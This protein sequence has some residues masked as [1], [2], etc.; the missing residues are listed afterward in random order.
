MRLATGGQIDRAQALSFTFDGRRYQGVAGDTLAS[1]L[2]ANDVRL[3]GRSFKYH[4]R[5]GIF[6]AGSEEPNALVTLGSGAEQDPNQRA[7]MVELVDGLDARSQNRWPSLDYDLLALN[8]L[9]APFLGAGFYYKTFMWPAKFWERLYEPLIRRAAGLG[10]LSGQHNPDRYERAFANCDLLVIGAGPAGLMAALEAGRAGLDVILCDEDTRPGGRLNAER[11]EVGGQ[12]G[13]EWAAGVVA[14]LRALA[15]VRVM[16]RTTVTGAYDGGTYGA[17]E[18]LSPEVAARDGAPQACFWRITARRA[19]LA[20]GALERPVAFRNNDRPG[21]M[22]AGALRTYVNRWAVAPGRSVVVFGNNDDAHR[23]VA[24]LLAAGVHVAALVDSRVDAHTDL[25][26]RLYAGAQ[27]CNVQGRSGVA[28]VSIATAGGVEKVQ[29]DC[30][31]MSGGWNP[32]LHL[33]C[34][35]GGRPEWSP[36]LAA[37]IP[38]AGAVPGMTAAGACAGV[39]STHGCLTAGAV[40]ARAVIDDLGHRAPA[41]DLPQAEDAPYRIAPLWTVPGK[42]RAWLDFQNDVTVKDVT[43]AA[44]ENFTSVEHMKRYTTQG[45][46]PDQGTRGLPRNG[47]PPATRPAPGWARR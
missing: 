32:T 44:A 23:T 2:M 34:H 12:S 46:A 21:V 40:A 33:T 15:N 9:A 43:Q 10:A 31:A 39:F 14:E 30:L 4:R 45:M 28:S 13:A 29:A 19:I 22:M 42:G 41:T 26:V 16:T 20:A 38:R 7:T 1:A 25:P 11:I 6:S 37:F 3:V 5:R 35:L 18:R 24:D 47:S 27:V 8:D 17:L 36:E